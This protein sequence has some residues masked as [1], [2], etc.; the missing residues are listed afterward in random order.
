[1]IYGI[2]NDLVALKRIENLYEK[3]GQ[4]L[5]NHVL[6]PIEQEELASA[7]NQANFIAKRF[8]AKEAFSKAVGSGLRSPVTLRNIGVGHHESGKPEF[9]YEP[10]LQRWLIQQGIRHVY[11]SLSDDGEYV[12]AFA[13]AER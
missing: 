2:G 11:L 6:H 4:N 5:V 9:F 8:A 7:N 12:L 13:I 1:M 10:P 3:Y